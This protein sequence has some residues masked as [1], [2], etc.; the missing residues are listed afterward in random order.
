MMNMDLK[1]LILL[2]AVSLAAIFA[3]QVYWLRGLYQTRLAET[4][5]R[6]EAAMA[7]ADV[8][9]MLLR[10][11]LLEDDDEVQ[12]D[13]RVS[14]G[15]QT[16]GTAVFQTIAN[17]RSYV[18]VASD[19]AG[20]HDVEVT[21]NT[22]TTT[23]TTIRTR[24]MQPDTLSPAE[25]NRLLRS[26][27]D[28]VDNLSHY[29]QRAMHSGIGVFRRP[30][31]AAY[32]TI[33]C[34]QLQAAGLL[35]PHLTEFV[36]YTDSTLRTDSV[37]ASIGTVGYRPSARARTYSYF[38]DIPN[39]IQY[40]VTME[41]VTAIVLR[42]MA[43]ILGTSLAILAVLVGVFAIL[44][45]TL[46]HMRSLDEM[47][48]DF[49]NNMTHEL[50][51]PIAIAYA[52]NDAL[53]NFPADAQPQRTRDYLRIGQEQ[54]QHLSGLV[55]QI[56]SMS[57]ERHKTVQ[58]HPEPVAVADMVEKLTEEF[59]L[60]AD[61]PLT[62]TYE[63]EPQGLTVMADRTHLYL[64]LGNLVDNAIKYSVGEATIYI[65]CRRQGREAQL[66]V[67]DRGI[68][69]P[70]DKLPLIF[71]R[72]YRVPRGNLHA[73]KG[74]GLGLFYVRSLM[75]RFGGTVTAESQV[76]RGSTFTLKWIAWNS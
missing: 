31:V 1:K 40:R 76:G 21:M 51:T 35:R 56:L 17:N 73:V 43:G 14:A 71:D 33:F 75:Q 26:M 15:Y 12:G 7:T 70:R 25:G 28:G 62:I 16:D 34:R 23:V 32:D 69:I 45:R 37:V 47:K 53:L 30:D 8:R 11:S 5:D 4:D 58:L 38:A 10:V 13:V 68:G 19:G 52:A 54:L 60:K 3:Y 55:E 24:P 9:E 66:S 20:Q 57:M 72:F 61:R 22:D 63:E 6:I 46:M 39:L 64:M 67:T 65:R 49:T 42:Q 74:Y 27:A 48:T 59:R 44:L 36:Q 41:P 2:V 50:K 29:L 18:G